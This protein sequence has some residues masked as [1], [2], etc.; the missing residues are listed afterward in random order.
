MAKIL[1]ESF[2]RLRPS[3]LEN[4]SNDA[5]TANQP[6]PPSYAESIQQF[7][8]SAQSSCQNTLSENQI[9]LNEVS[10]FI[11]NSIRRSARPSRPQRDSIVN[12]LSD[13]DN[14]ETIMNLAES[15]A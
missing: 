8:R 9:T 10:Q 14:S 2:R 11:R 15:A 4:A 6:S 12:I 5:E 7:C 3:L 13:Q 1:R